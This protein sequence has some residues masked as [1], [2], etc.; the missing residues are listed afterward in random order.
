MKDMILFP[1][2]ID[3][4]NAVL[5]QLVLKANLLLAVLINKDGRLLTSQGSLEIVDTVSMAA[6]VAGNSASTLA[7]ANLM[8]ET[9]FS[10]MYHQGKEKHIYIAVVDENTFLAL[11]FDDRTNIDRVKVFARQFDRQLKQSLEQVYNKTEDQIDLDLGMGYDPMS[12]QQS[13][14]ETF[15]SDQAFS[16]PQQNPIAFPE[17]SPP[18]QNFVPPEQMAPMP[19]PSEYKQ[20]SDEEVFYIESMQKKKM[21]E[22]ND[23]N[24]LYLKNKIRETKI[25]KDK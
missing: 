1:E 25:K 24:R 21:A 16:E 7:I 4:L 6:L 2:D 5:S 8:G 13:Y 22:S 17:S 12:Q 9:E 10:T 20:A 18:V 15:M 11:V 23:T 3:Q 19:Q 14:P